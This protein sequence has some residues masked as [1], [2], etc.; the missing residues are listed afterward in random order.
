MPEL[1]ENQFVINEGLLKAVLLYL[2]TKPWSEVVK[3]IEAL[4]TLPKFQNMEEK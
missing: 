3:L 4:Q 2:S 1:H